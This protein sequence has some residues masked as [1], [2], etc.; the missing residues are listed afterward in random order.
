MPFVNQIVQLRSLAIVGTAKNT[1]KTET[2]NYV[3]RR[4]AQSDHKRTIA[5]TSIGID[6]ERRDQVTQTDKPEIELQKGCY[7]VTAEKFYREKRLPAEVIG[8][9]QRYT[10]SLGRTIYARARG[11][12]KVL[13]GG[14][15]SSIGLTHIVSVLQQ[16]YG[17]DL[18]LI[19]GALSRLSLAAPTVAEGMIL[20][21]GAAYS[22]QPTQLVQRMRDLHRLIT[23]PRVESGAVREQLLTVEQGVRVI[24]AQGEVYD[25]GFESVLLPSA[26]QETSWLTKGDTLYV[27]GIVSDTLLDRLRLIEGHLRLVVCDFT[28]IFASGQ[29]V[30]RYLASGRT[31]ETLYSTTLVA[32]TFNPLAPSGYRLDSARMCEQLQEVLGTPV[33]DVRRL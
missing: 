32:V 2:L 21:T 14:P 19:D 18:T 10:T 23:L 29:N 13:I 28:R 15:S 31:I 3:L 7:F 25:P 12:G 5:L 16:R 33:Y 27:A 9:D 11:R 17:V 22:A 24:T 20:A 6:G 26:W 4:L 1:G 8:I 30:N